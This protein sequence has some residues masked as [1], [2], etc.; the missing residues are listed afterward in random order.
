[1]VSSHEDGVQL[2]ARWAAA[3]TRASLPSACKQ[4][5]SSVII[6]IG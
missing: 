1:M 2:K 4:Q 5:K 3:H 6:I